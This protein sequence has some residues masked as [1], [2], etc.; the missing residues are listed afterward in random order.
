MTFGPGAEGEERRL[1]W[2]RA[3]CGALGNAQPERVGC[4]LCAHMYKGGFC[5]KVRTK[6]VADAN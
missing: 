1:A 3:T 4:A 2:V 5:P 6:E